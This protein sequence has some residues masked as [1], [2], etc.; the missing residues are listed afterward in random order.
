MRRIRGILMIVSAVLAIVLGLFLGEEISTLWPLALLFATF[1]FCVLGGLL[2]PGKIPAKILGGL[3]LLLPLISGFV[4]GRY[5][6]TTAFQES[7]DRAKVVQA[8]L[9]A[10]REATGTFPDRLED[11]EVGGDL[12]LPGRRLLRGRVLRYRSTPTEYQLTAERWS[13]R[14]AGDEKTAFAHVPQEEK[15]P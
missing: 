11:L 4:A 13:L 14:F 15:A 3:M 2:T 8:A 1:G 12:E 5:E 10:H 9:A 7:V 6:G